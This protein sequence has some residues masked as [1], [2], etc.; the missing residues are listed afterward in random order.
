M[1]SN[2][3]RH[4]VARWASTIV[5][6]LSLGVLSACD[7]LLGVDIKAELTD[8][9]LNDPKSAETILVSAITQFEDAYN[10]YTWLVHHL[11]DGGEAPINTSAT[12]GGYSVYSSSMVGEQFLGMSTSLNFARQL[13]DKLTNDW[14]VEQVPS[15]SRYLA[16]TSLYSGAAV[17][18]FGEHLCEAALNGGP[19]LT[20][21]QTLTEADRFLTQ[22]LT[23]IQAVGDFAV[24]YG[25][26]TSARAMAQGLRAQVRWTAGDKT[27]ALA[28]AQAVPKGFVALVTRGAAANRRNLPY[29]AGTFNG[30]QEQ[31]GV[32]DWWKGLE[33][34]VTRQPWPTVIPFTGYRDLGILPNGRAVREDGLPIRTEGPYRTAEESAAVVD[35]R[36]RYVRGVIQGGPTNGY[37]N[38]RYSGNADPIPLV[39][40]KEMWLIRAELEGGARAIA[41]VN[42]IRAADNLPLVTYADPNNVKQI[43]YMLIEER[44]R[45][46]YTEGRYYPQKLKRPDLLWF[47]RRSGFS[48]IAAKP[49]EGGVA[50]LMPESEYERN[51][52]L[53]LA[54]R[55]TGCDPSIRP[56]F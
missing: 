19:L 9:V 15:R 29:F 47:P 16:L 37:R 41:L 28:D 27:G 5:L 40:W 10:L 18:V 12:F 20:R 1:D 21:A 49:L 42:E 44:R 24:P 25:V 53:T 50:V 22:A 30:F 31:Y 55:G 4:R 38:A 2:V 36:V 39:N 26:A 14:T 8:D 23:E 3:K 7:A 46:L 45:A 17:R 51:T 32:I 43:E 11:E 35:R 34:P 52:N 6:G 13:H 33:N 48:P 54:M 56:L